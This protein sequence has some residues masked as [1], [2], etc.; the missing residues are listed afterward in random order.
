MVLVDK[1]FRVRG[2]YLVDKVAWERTPESGLSGVG[3]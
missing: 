1:L 2:R 3:A